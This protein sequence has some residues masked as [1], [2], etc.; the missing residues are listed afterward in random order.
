MNLIYSIPSCLQSWLLG[1]SFFFIFLFFQERGKKEMGKARISPSSFYIQNRRLAEQTL[2][3]P[4]FDSSS[5]ETYWPL[6]QLRNFPARL[7]KLIIGHK[8]INQNSL[9]V[10]DDVTRVR[11]FGFLSRC[12][13]WGVPPA[14]RFFEVKSPAWSINRSKFLVLSVLGSVLA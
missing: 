13:W 14:R 8:L 7:H 11:R 6:L 12:L 10:K 4:A 9:S 2:K 3:T 5:P 1:N